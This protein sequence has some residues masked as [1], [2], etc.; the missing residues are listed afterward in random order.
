[1]WVIFALLDPNPDPLTRL[2]P[3]PI[4]IRICNTEKNPIAP[5]VIVEA[6]YDVPAHVEVEWVLG[7]LVQQIR[8]LHQLRPEVTGLILVAV[9]CNTSGKPIH[10]CT[11]INAQLQY[12][13]LVISGNDKQ[14]QVCQCKLALTSR[15]TLFAI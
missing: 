5:G 2:N 15:N 3:D 12:T 7:C 6:V 4:R 8:G 10:Q 11:F 9:L 14:K 1:M 13:P